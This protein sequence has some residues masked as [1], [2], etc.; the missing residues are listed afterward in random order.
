[1]TLTKLQARAVIRL[2]GVLQTHLESAIETS[3]IGGKLDGEPDPRDK[4]AVH[5]VR[6]DRR[7]WRVAEDL[8]IKLEAGLR[9]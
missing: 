1:M 7:D 3:V 6:L 8:I 2:L 4:A 5:N 9:G